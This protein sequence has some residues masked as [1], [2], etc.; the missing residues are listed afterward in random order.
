MKYPISP[1]SPLGIAFS[2]TTTKHRIVQVTGCAPTGDSYQ[3]VGWYEPISGFGRSMGAVRVL[4]NGAVEQATQPIWDDTIG[5]HLARAMRAFG[6]E[7]ENPCTVDQAL[8]VVRFLEQ[9]A[10]PTIGARIAL[11]P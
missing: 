7:H 3:I 6:D 10:R 8:R 1:F 9:C 5:A 4:K 11:T 2:D